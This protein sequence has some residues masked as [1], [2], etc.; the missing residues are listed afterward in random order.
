MQVTLIVG[1]LE[2]EIRDGGEPRAIPRREALSAPDDATPLAP[3]ERELLDELT[4]LCR[5]ILIDD[6][7]PQALA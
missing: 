6:A 5:G 1:G 7:P 3:D 4:R 2:R